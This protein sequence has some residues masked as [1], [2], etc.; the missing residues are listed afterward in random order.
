[1]ENIR[2]E[3][4]T[5]CSVDIPHG[6]FYKDTVKLPVYIISQRAAAFLMMME[7]VANFEDVE[8]RNAMLEQVRTAGLPEKANED[9]SVVQESVRDFVREVELALML[10]VLV[11]GVEDDFNA[12]D[13]D[14]A[15]GM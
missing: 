2:F 13:N 11:G 6:F 12:E 4:C 8:V 9:I 10:D 7:E 5:T 15:R 1:M 3:K 14:Y